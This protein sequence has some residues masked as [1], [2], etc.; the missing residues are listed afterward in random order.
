MSTN[1]VKESRRSY[2][3]DAANELVASASESS[4]D[5]ATFLE[6]FTTLAS[7]E[8][9]IARLRDL[10]LEL[11][12]QGRCSQQLPADDDSAELLKSILKERQ[13]VKSD[14]RIPTGLATTDTDF[15]KPD[16]WQT[17][18]LGFLSLQIQYGYTASAIPGSDGIRMLRITD[19]QNNHVDWSSVPGCEISDEE[20]K[21]YLLHNND[22]LIARTGGTIGKSYI[23][24]TVFELVPRNQLTRVT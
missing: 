17:T 11:T 19:I 15:A 10:V 13:A 9:G 6:K 22:I 14:Y 12:F 7:V 1:T 23:V 8:N 20:A 24:E 5:A 2:L 4:F 18:T 21:K 16:S 3:A